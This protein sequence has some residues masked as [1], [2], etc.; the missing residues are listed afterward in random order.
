MPNGVYRID[1]FGKAHL[2]SNLSAFERNHP[3]QNPDSS[4]YE[5]DGSFYS[6][7]NVRGVLYVAA[8]N[9]QEIIRVGPDGKTTRVIDL[10]KFFDPKLHD[11]R[12]V[13]GLAYANGNF[14]VGTLGEFPLEPGSQGIY[15][16][17]PDGFVRQDVTGLTGVVNLTFHNGQLYALETSTVAGQPTPGTG[18]VVRITSS[19]SLQTVASGLSNPTAMTFGPDGSLYVSNWGYGPPTAGQIVKIHV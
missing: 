15:E 13:T 9:H 12:G 1:H 6:M 10:S 8:A 18:K 16:V 11:W 14:F 2:L 4:D 7:I 17:T 3:V 5:P 19:G